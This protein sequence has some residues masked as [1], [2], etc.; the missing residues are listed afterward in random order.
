MKM[1]IK[2]NLLLKQKKDL[3]KVLKYE[4]QL[5]SSF[6]DNLTEAGDFTGITRHPI[7]FNEAQSEQKIG[8][9]QIRQWAGHVSDFIRKNTSCGH[10]KMN[11]R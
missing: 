8:R 4:Q 5:L 11:R 1:K 10:I 7:R 3:E 9:I 6:M 2:Y